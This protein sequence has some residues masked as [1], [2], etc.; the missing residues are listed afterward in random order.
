MSGNYF[1]YR[2]ENS[3]VSK[4]VDRMERR[5]RNTIRQREEDIIETMNKNF[6]KADSVIYH[7]GSKQIKKKLKRKKYV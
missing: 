1:N 4:W 3:H 7:R 6:A 2:A 5:H